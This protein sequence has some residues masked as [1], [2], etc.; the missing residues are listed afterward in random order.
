MAQYSG[1]WNISHAV[2][3]AKNNNWTGIAPSNVE[4]LIVA[5][6][7]GGGE[8][9]GGGGGAGGLLAKIC[10]VITGTGYAITV[11]G[12]GAASA[13]GSDSVFNSLTAV[14]GGR[15]GTASGPTPGALGGSGGGGGS[16]NGTNNVNAGG[17]GPGGCPQGGPAHGLLVLAGGR[18][19]WRGPG[20]WRGAAA[21]A[22]RGAGA[23][24][25]ARTR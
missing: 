5:G 13:N 14:G 11:G 21:R 19:G 17:G 8:N 15:G 24:H 12:G 2:Q 23:Q 18:R 10:S 1:V 3:A 25:A 7:G 20:L 6:G 9:Q 22:R 4:Y 16:S